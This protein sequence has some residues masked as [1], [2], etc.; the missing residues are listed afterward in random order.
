MKTNIDKISSGLYILLG[1]FVLLWITLGF[2]KWNVVFQFLRLWPLFFVVV[3]I[4]I[5]FSRTKLF[6]LKVLSPVIV[7]GS[8][9]AVIYVSQNGDLFHPRKIEIFKANL[10]GASADKTVDLNVDFSSGKLIITDEDENR[11]SANLSAPA[12]AKPIINFKEFE[13]ENLYEISGNPS[14]KYVFSPWDGEHLWDVRIGKEIPVKIKAQ[15]Y[16][17][18][19][20]FDGSNLLAADFV[21]DT[22][23]S[24]NNII[25]SDNIKKARIDSLCSTL[26]ILIPKEMGVK[27]SLD[28]MFIA[29]N[30]EKLGLERGFKNYTSPNYEKAEKK[31]DLD[32]SLKFSQLEIRFY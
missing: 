23:F 28:K 20:K 10:S 1:G 12:G 13:E 2:I 30:F 9:F 18:V 14:G 16:A 26:A 19:N 21:L 5:I 27:I 31:I 11:V 17:S 32:L 22:K 24:S 6:F 8:V 29:D 7:I 15:T 4:D 25:F 3:G